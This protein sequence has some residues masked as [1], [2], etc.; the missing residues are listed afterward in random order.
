MPSLEVRTTRSLSFTPLIHRHQ[1]IV[2][3]FQEWDHPLA[4]SIRTPNVT[5]RSTDACPRTTQPARPFR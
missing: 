2:V 4:L 1:K 3:Q 5:A